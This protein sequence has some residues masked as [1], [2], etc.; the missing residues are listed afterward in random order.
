M[1]KKLCCILTLIV[2]LLNS[3]V[4]IIVSEAVDAI[5]TSLVHE[6]VKPIIEMK[7]TKYENF[8][9]TTENSSTGSKGAIIQTNVKTGIEYAEGQEYKA[10]QKTISKIQ[11]PTISENKPQRVEVIIRSTKATNGGKTANYEYD[12]DTGVVTIVAENSEYTEN[13]PEARDEYD[14]IFIYDSNCYIN[15]NEERSFN[16]KVDVTE[17]IADKE[18]PISD[19]KDETYTVSENISSIISVSQET[20]DIYDGYITANSLNTENQYETTY[21]ETLKIMVSNKE[22]AQKI[23][24]NANSSV[25]LYK[26]TIIDKNQVLDIIGENGSIDILDENGKILKTINKDSETGEDGKI[27][28][29]YENKTQNLIIQLNNIEKEGIIEIQNTRVI[30]TDAQI[31]DDTFLTIISIQGIN[32]VITEEQGEKGETVTKEVDQ[33]KYERQGESSTQIKQAVSNIDA[34]LNV[35]N[36][37]NNVQNDVLLTLTLRTDNPKYSLFKDPTISIEIPEEVEDIILGTTELMHNNQI[38]TITYSGV[39]ANENGNKVVNLTLQGTQT[40][41]ES[42]SVVDGTNILIPLT[43]HLK[44]QMTTK[45]AN[46]K[47]TYTNK[48]TNTTEAK[49]ME[50]SL[51]NKIATIIP[52]TYSNS[53]ENTRIFEANG[54]KVEIIEEV[55]NSVIPESGTLYEQQI[56]KNTIKITNN[57]STAKKVK[58]ISSIPKEMT[59]VELKTG[60]Y[61]Y[62]E[63]KNYYSHSNLYEY[64][65]YEEKG[66]ITIE[67]NIEPGSTETKYFELKVKDLQEEQQE[68]QTT[69]NYD[70]QINGVNYKAISMKNTIKKAEISVTLNC[71]MEAN[72]NDWSFKITITNLTDRE[73]KNVNIAFEASPIFEIKSENEYIFGNIDRNFWTYTLDSLE[74]IKIGEHGEYETGQACYIIYGE[75]NDIDE[76]KGYDYDLNGVATIYNDEIGTYVSNEARM[77]GNIEAVEVTMTSDKIEQKLKMDDEITYTVNI[78]NTGKTREGIAIYENVN[79]LD[80]IPRELQPIT[81]KYNKYIIHEEYVQD[82]EYENLQHKVQTYTEETVECDLS[83]LVIPEGYT[84][85]DAPNIDYILQIPNGKSV[86]IEI[87]AKVRMLQ[88]ETKITNTVIV[89]GEYIKTKTASLSNI[90]LNYDY[91]E[92]KEP[93]RPDIPIDPNN[94]DVPINPDDNDDKTTTQKISIS[95]TAWIDENEDGKRTSDE[96]FLGNMSVIL[97]DYKN[98]KFIDQIQTDANGIYLFK[99]LF[100]S[101]YIVIF[102]Y[103]TSLYT[104]TE[105]RK[106][107]VIENRNSDAITKTV[108][109]NG[110]KIV[111]GLTDTLE[112]ENNL[113]NIDIGLIKNKQFDLEMQKYISKITIQTKDNTKTYTYDSKQLAKVEVNSKKIDGAT[114]IIEYK[115]IIT[116]KGEIA[117]KATQI[118]DNLPDGLKFYSELNSNWYENNGK[119]YTTSLAGEKIGVGESR[120]IKLVLT[121]NLNS[122]NVG[123][124]TNTVLIGISSNDKAVEDENIINNSSKAEVI[125]GISTGLAKWIGITIGTLLILIILFTLIRKNKKHIKI[126]SFIL[127]LGICL[128]GNIPNSFGL[129]IKGYNT[130]KNGEIAYGDDGRTYTCDDKNANFC[131]NAWHDATLKSSS[132]EI[133]YEEQ[134]PDDSGITVSDATSNNGVNFYKIYNNKNEVD[135]TYN[136]VGPFKVNST[137]SDASCSVSVEYKDKDGNTG[138]SNFEIIGFSWGGDFYIKVPNTVIQITKVKVTGSY[139]YTQSRTVKK[140]ITEVYSTTP[141]GSGHPPRC[142][143]TAAN[144]YKGKVGTQD[145]KIEAKDVDATETRSVSGS[146]SVDINGPWTAYG[147]LQ[148]EKVDKDNT[149]RVLTNISFKIKQNAEENRYL[150][151][152]DENGTVVKSIETTQ[153]SLDVSKYVAEGELTK[154]NPSKAKINDQTYY[155]NFNSNSSNA[156]SIVA[157]TGEVLI[158]GLRCGKY[159]FVEVENPNYGY[160]ATVY[161]ITTGFPAL[162]QTTWKITNEKQTGNL[163]IKKIDDR[164]TN[165][166]LP[167]VEFVLKSSI[168]SQYIKVKA[169]GDNVTADS[170]GW[171]T[172]TVGRLVV[173]NMSYTSDI[174]SATK[175]VTNSSG[176]IKICNLL[177][178]SYGS[179]KIAYYLEEI[180]NPNYGYIID[181]GNYRNYRV[182]FDENA[183][184]GWVTVPRQSIYE[185]SNINSGAYIGTIVKN[186]QIYIRLSGNVWEDQMSGKSND[187]NNMMDDGEPLI[188]GIKVYLYKN[189]Q[190]IA[191]TQTDENGYYQFGTQKSSYDNNDYWNNGEEWAENGNLIIDN[192]DQYYIEF[193]YDGL[194]FTTVATNWDYSSKDEIGSKAYE[195]PSSRADGKDRATVNYDFTEITNGYSRDLK[196]KATYK[197]NYE[198]AD[199]ESKY[200]NYWGYEYTTNKNNKKLLKVTY[201]YDKDDYYEVISSTAQSGFSIKTKWE[202]AY[203]NTGS[204]VIE[205]NNQGLV[206][207]EQPDLAISSD[208]NKVNILVAGYENTYTYEKRKDYEN[209]NEN[210]ANYD[211]SMDGF[212]VE[213]KF[214]DK[215]STR[216]SNRGL[217]TYTRRIYESDLALYN[218]TYNQDKD[219][220]QV[221]V[222]YKM[223]VTNQSV[224]L[225]AKVNEIVNYYDER[226]EIVKSWIGDDENKNN[227]TQTW[228]ENG[229]YGVKYNDDGYIANYTQAIS[230]MEIAPNGY[231][232]IYIKFRVLPSAVH[233]LMNQQSTLNNVCEITSFSTGTKPNGTWNAYAGIDEDSNPGST[234]IKFETNDIQTEA[235]GYEI[236]NK[237]LDKTTYE[238]DTDF[239]PSLILGIEKDNPTRGLSGT[240]FEDW[241]SVE[242]VEGKIRQGDGI[243]VSTE[244]RI[245]NAKVDLIE[246][247]ANGTIISETDADGNIVPKIATL[248]KLKIKNTGGTRQCET[249]EVEATVYTNKNGEYVF[250]GVIPDRYLIRYTYGNQSYIIKN[251]QEY[252]YNKKSGQTGNL[253]ENT[254]YEDKME[255]RNSDGEFVGPIN[256]RDYKSTIITSEEIKKAL[257][258]KR[259]V[260]PEKAER[261]GNLNWI[262]IHEGGTGEQTIRYSDAAD[263]LTKRGEADDLFYGTYGKNYTMSADTAVFDVGVEYSDVNLE[264]KTWTDY[265]DEFDIADGVVVLDN[266]RIKLKPTF[267]A[268]NP[269]Q[270]FGIVERA[271]QDFRV[272]KRISDLKIVLSTGQI[273]INGNPYKEKLPYVKAMGNEVLAE[274]DNEI[275]QGAKLEIEYTITI[276]NHSEM[277]Y[278]YRKDTSY[279]YYGEVVDKTELITAIRK[280][281][282]YMDDDIVYDEEKNIGVWKKTTADELIAW[283]Q[284]SGEGTKQ[285]IA[286]DDL[287]SGEKCDVYGDLKAG[288][289]TVAVTE[290]FYSNGLGI[291]EAKSV[292]IYGSKMLSTKGE[293]INLENHTEI[294]ETQG[295]RSVLNSIPGDYS[296]KYKKPNEQDD[297]LAKLII[298]P[299]TGLFENKIFILTMTTVILVVLA[300]GI[301]LIKKKVIG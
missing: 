130:N 214:G 158:K 200:I 147:D 40:S 72:R 82:D 63:E 15:N 173:D 76:E 192:L 17:E 148:I 27:K 227:I 206:K 117:G 20:E 13:I 5:Q 269:Y 271:R 245:Y 174:N 22:I 247:D 89:Q 60:G 68:T 226:Y 207:R 199:H 87:K 29:D 164:N 45:M 83:S 157:K 240:V 298:T 105:Y 121:K 140:T 197:L 180:K 65:E 260:V 281:V 288:G 294:I 47:I 297:D 104:L 96:S 62:N 54:I 292:K 7:L 94:P 282:D 14:V 238:D 156:T 273:L 21:N 10:I 85:E 3:S 259:A 86:T 243:H 265:K 229:K 23:K 110:E 28:V 293:G 284:D 59:Y 56:V 51:L 182:T 115:M 70:I 242:T 160:T 254:T 144:P 145:M 222:T 280:V 58:I 215:Y 132:E 141:S 1:R 112:A 299:P 133:T 119:L 287:V 301:Y 181:D 9:T 190:I 79:V 193:E 12:K 188:S 219:L 116:N 8:D 139:S 275:L 285:L 128:F 52:T 44:K 266:G 290:Y 168:N 203:Q 177:T 195:V 248:Y 234:E 46:F 175:F 221:Y 171:A 90:L 210:D 50:V 25:A 194:S 236:E 183:P 35:D 276:E 38:F 61:I 11:V 142:Y 244:N 114:A 224:N 97:Y 108:N 202:N 258:L 125:I 179:D 103:D 64:E 218:K 106:Q 286:K 88:E 53:G 77:R 184:N 296:P 154:N 235:D 263:D 268:V 99:N 80:C 42:S 111:A 33:V 37:V 127:V 170:N 136:K 24:I 78:K 289:Y 134:W 146:S 107:G 41:Y 239:S 189:G 169:T 155:I 34:K 223:R 165:K 213:V 153:I 109:L 143:S 209:Q 253:D 232:D 191:T 126:A 81:A 162:K 262:L 176:E 231:I 250:E 167:N 100:K 124:I 274:I 73:L 220:M 6:Q 272:E 291:G 186:H 228:T 32:S 300:G 26:E 30:G 161:P 91:E 187:N 31:K 261:M 120:E 75:V 137:K 4:M 71:V 196:G 252:T 283:N 122:N 216:Y 233:D 255:I 98:K 152:K 16:I 18:T 208:I 92:P 241:T 256:V 151:I 19:S 2:L 48:M 225:T 102:L 123:T 67:V 257:N 39:N 131:D 66:Q 69:I 95:G 159:Q 204:E 118:V 166:V 264:K 270:D 277:D 267:Y 113:T 178:S 57:N 150:Q 278:D 101:Q 230:N 212:G 217:N 251:G 205:H 201:D 74:P 172:R 49:D 135:D 149:D 93:G 249:E 163:Y 279:Y 185:T 55:G 84:E 129:Q 211:E 198:L 36:F 43:I 138:N 295:I 237:I 246:T